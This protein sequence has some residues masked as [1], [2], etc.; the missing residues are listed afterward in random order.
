M[1]EVKVLALRILETCTIEA[2]ILRQILVGL[3]S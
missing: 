3:Q 1:Q 2:G